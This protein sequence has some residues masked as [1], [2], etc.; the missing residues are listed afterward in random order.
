MA[1]LPTTRYR[2]QAA[3]ATHFQTSG[4]FTHDPDVGNPQRAFNFFH[5][6]SPSTDLNSR[7]L[8]QLGA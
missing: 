6:R 4:H 1:N 2:L 8:A 7:G 3:S 5:Q